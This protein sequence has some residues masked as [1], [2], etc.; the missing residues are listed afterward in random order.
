[1]IK[2]IAIA[3]VALVGAVLIFAATKPDTFRIERSTLIKA[4]PERV[5]ALIDDFHQWEKWSPWER[6]DP[7]LQRTYSGANSGKGAVYAWNGNK[8]VGAG[9][10]EI[11]ESTPPAKIVLTLDFSAPFEAH[12]LVQFSLDPQ[13]DATKLTQAMYGPSPYVSKLMGIFFDMDKMVGDKYEEGL[14]SIKALAEKNAP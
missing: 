14:A 5:F 12:N 10:M 6:I 4:P 13:G 3:V 9:R 7:Q 1:M 2:R 11:V 8:D